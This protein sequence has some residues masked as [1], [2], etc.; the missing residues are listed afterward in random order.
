MVFHQVGYTDLITWS[1]GRG[2][3]RHAVEPSSDSGHA[4]R[5]GLR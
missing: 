5:N 3:T 2:R 4:A 1:L